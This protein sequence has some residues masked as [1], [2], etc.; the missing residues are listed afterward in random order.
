[1]RT[2]VLQAKGSRR[3]AILVVEAAGTIQVDEAM[4]VMVMVMVMTMTMM[5]MYQTP[6]ELYFT[7]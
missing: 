4:K 3:E 7:C 1:M 2:G 6:S 5:L